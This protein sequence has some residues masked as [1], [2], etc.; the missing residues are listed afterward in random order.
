MYHTIRLD[1]KTVMG[2]K[3]AVALIAC[4]GIEVNLG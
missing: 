4:S 2:L 3:K 1:K